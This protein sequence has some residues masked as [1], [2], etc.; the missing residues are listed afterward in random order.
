MH[1]KVNTR[2]D[3]NGVSLPRKAMIMCGL[4]CDADGIWRKEQLSSDLNEIVDKYPEQL[5]G[6][7]PE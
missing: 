1:E 6:A 7:L 5:N 2:K 3:E 4:A